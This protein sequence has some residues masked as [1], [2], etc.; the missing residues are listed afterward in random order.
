MTVRIIFLSDMFHVWQTENEKNEK[1]K[2]KHILQDV[3]PHCKWII[4]NMST[5][6]LK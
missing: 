5:I 4:L 1:K 3:V 6:D 2:K